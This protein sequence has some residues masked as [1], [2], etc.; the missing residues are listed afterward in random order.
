[1][2]TATR[3]PVRLNY[4][5]SNEALVRGRYARS[6]QKIQPGLKSETKL[7]KLLAACSRFNVIRLKL[8]EID[9]YC[10]IMIMY[11]Y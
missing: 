2:V 7:V 5:R 3:T 1:M 8:L 9:Y 6:A 11:T 4:T 10:R